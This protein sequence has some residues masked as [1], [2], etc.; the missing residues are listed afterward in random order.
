MLVWKLQQMQNATPRGSE[1][2]SY[3]TDFEDVA[4][5]AYMFSGPI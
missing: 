4:L 5:A 3:H 2:E 1:E